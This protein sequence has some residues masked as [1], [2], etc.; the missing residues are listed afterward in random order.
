MKTNKFGEMIFDE[1]DLCNSIMKGQPVWTVK[2]I[3]V[4]TVISL[5]K[6]I[7]SLEDTGLLLTWRSPD[8]R[9]ISV[10][11]FDLERQSR[12]F[13][14][15]EYKNMD[16]AE[17]ILGVCTTQE[18]LQ[19]VGEELILYQEKNLFDLLRYLKYLVDVM[20]DNQIIW[21][22]GRGSSVA[23]YVLYILGVHKIDSLYYDLD[24]REF[25]R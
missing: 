13:I 9:D 25:L 21:G 6:L 16:I 4:D 18:Q 23:S 5:E 3:T 10:E 11:E 19:R 1:S 2:N 20:R 24:I 22:V 15:D 8:D 17:F 12:W 14:P 7:E